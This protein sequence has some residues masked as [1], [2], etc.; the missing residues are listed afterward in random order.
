MN[1]GNE[2][3]TERWRKEEND[4]PGPKVQD[5]LHMKEDLVC[6]LHQRDLSHRPSIAEHVHILAGTKKINLDY[7][8]RPTLA[9]R[10][11][12]LVVIVES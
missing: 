11:G 8:E 7:I 12:G 1:C 2:Y 10:S 6:C 3:S 9:N 4:N 5:L